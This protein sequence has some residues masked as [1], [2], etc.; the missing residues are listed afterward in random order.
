MKYKLII[1]IGLGI[2]IVLVVSGC[3]EGKNYDDNRGNY[4]RSIET[5]SSECEKIGDNVLEKA[6]VYYPEGF[7]CSSWLAEELYFS[8]T[9]CSCYRGKEGEYEVVTY[10]RSTGSIITINENVVFEETLKE[11]PDRYS[12]DE[13]MVMVHIYGNNTGLG[14][15]KEWDYDFYGNCTE[16]R[17]MNDVQEWVWSYPRVKVY[18]N[19]YC[20]ILCPGVDTPIYVKTNLN[21]THT[22]MEA[23]QLFFIA[24][25]TLN[26]SMDLKCTHKCYGVWKGYNC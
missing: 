17:Y 11:V 18:G 16:K 8:K 2:V 1:V 24:K 20:K 5:F 14:T 3:L 6:N 12:E 13:D 4:Q 10:Y 23:K 25:D 15:T 22:V 26:N 21:N 19:I 7:I 9:K